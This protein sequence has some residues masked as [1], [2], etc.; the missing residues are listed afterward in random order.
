MRKEV[1]VPLCP[2][3]VLTRAR[4]KERTTK[5]QLRMLLH[6]SNGLKKTVVL[7]TSR[8]AWTSLWWEPIQSHMSHG[9]YSWQPQCIHSYHPPAKKTELHLPNNNDSHSLY[10]PLW[11][12]YWSWAQAFICFT[13]DL[14]HGAGVRLL[15]MQ[16]VY[17]RTL[18]CGPLDGRLICWGQLQGTSSSQTGL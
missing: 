16:R 17:P 8:F 11:R 5:E 9:V 6:Y 13:L 14:I 7:P 2:S 10:N 4:R 18:Q 12:N 15:V 1:R 3:A